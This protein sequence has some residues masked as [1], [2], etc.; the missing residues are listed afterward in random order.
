MVGSKIQTI[1]VQKNVKR[2]FMNL[3]FT[4]SARMN[5]KALRACE[6]EK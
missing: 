4:G 6:I 3:L 2:N 5:N 1:K